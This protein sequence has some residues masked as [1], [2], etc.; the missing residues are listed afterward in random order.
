MML[1]KHR[2]IRQICYNIIVLRIVTIKIDML[3]SKSLD[4]PDLWLIKNN[5]FDLTANISLLS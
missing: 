4:Q 3:T 1:S 2:I 5:W